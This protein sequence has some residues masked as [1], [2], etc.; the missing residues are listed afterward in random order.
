MQEIGRFGYVINLARVI[1]QLVRKDAGC[2]ANAVENAG[3][4]VPNQKRTGAVIL[5][6]VLAFDGR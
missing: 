3:D 2:V 6:A 1:R 4:G 5:V